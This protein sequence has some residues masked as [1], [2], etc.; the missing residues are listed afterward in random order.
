MQQ[1]SSVHSIRDLSP[2]QREA[3]EALLG[4]TLGEEERVSVRVFSGQLVREAPVGEAREK[5]FRELSAS[6]ERIA[7]RAEGIPDDELDAAIGEAANY[8]RHTR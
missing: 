8:V 2:A 5:A 3:L 7:K 1:D 6:M 4:R